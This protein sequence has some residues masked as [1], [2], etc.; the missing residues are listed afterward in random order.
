MHETEYELAECQEEK[1]EIWLEWLLDCHIVV[2]VTVVVELL[3][4]HYIQEE[5]L[6]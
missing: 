5:V 2:V 3:V 1:S 4:K 6:D